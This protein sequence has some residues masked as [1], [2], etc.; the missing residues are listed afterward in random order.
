MKGFE[1]GSNGGEGMEIR[2]MVGVFGVP[3]MV[4]GMIGG[5]TMTGVGVLGGDTITGV[6]VLQRPEVGGD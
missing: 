5:D 2:G 6:G 4:I 3:G 1:F